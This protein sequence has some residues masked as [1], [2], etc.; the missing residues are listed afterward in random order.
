MDYDGGDDSVFDKPLTAKES[1]SKKNKNSWWNRLK[2]K[3]IKQH[4]PFEQDK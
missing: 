1:I 3:F 2:S 4:C